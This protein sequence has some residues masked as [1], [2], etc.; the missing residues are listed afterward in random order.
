MK[1]AIIILVGG[2]IILITGVVIF[3]SV[4]WDKRY[5]PPF[6]EITAS[7]DSATIARG[8][9]LAYGPAHCATCHVPMDKIREVENGLEIPLS[10]GWELAIPPGTFRAPNLTP[11]AETGIGSLTD[12][13]LA[14]ALRHSVK[15]NG[16]M[17]FPFMPFQEMSDEDLTAVISFLRSQPAVKHDVKPTEM[18]F[19]GKAIIAFGLMKPESAK[20]TPPKTVARDSSAL[21]GEYLATSV[22]NC[23]GCHTERDLKSGAYVGQPYAGGTFFEPD[24]FSE[25]Y[26][27]ITPN[28]TPETES[29][30][31][32]RWT[33][34]N[35]ITRF[36]TGRVHRGSPMPWG[37]FSRIDTVEL[38]ALYRY[39]RTVEPVNRK[40]EKVV[41][42]PGEKAAD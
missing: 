39:L 37:A 17:M 42:A 2:L 21:Y 4:S 41:F 25:G 27:Y 13:Q 7:T 16:R 11:D 38:K 28:L 10:G 9:Y 12:G 20:N 19:I 15:R 40:F 30:I 32:A 3:V 35:F 18:G 1:K 34:D 23:R 6:P 31:M 24:P 14:R 5:D 22:A 8:K 33:E 36:K 29:G 26:S